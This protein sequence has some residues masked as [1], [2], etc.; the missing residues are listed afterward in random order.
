MSAAPRLASLINLARKPKW[1]FMPNPTHL[2]AA[3]R[4][5]KSYRCRFCLHSHYRLS[6][7]KPSAHG[8]CPLD[9]YSGDEQRISRAL[10]QLLKAWVESAGSINNLRVFV[11][12]KTTDPAEFVSRT[13][14]NSAYSFFTLMSGFQ[15]PGMEVEGR[16]RASSGTTRKSLRGHIT[17]YGSLY[18]VTHTHSGVDSNFPETGASAT[19]TRPFGY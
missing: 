4:K 9:L 5:I 6:K 16:W 19:N 3:T 18:C 14:L 8:Y 12:G 15:S 17:T 7:G 1:G 10:R 11:N 13:P 2:S